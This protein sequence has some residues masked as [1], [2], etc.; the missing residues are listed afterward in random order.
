MLL[1]QN[2]FL[3]IKQIKFKD[4]KKY[5]DQLNEYKETINNQ[6]SKNSEML[7]ILDYNFDFF[8]KY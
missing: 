1:F 8:V 6:I 4:V 2:T 3:A 7:E 5:K